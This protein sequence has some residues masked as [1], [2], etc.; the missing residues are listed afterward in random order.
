MPGCTASSA[1]LPSLLSVH[2]LLLDANAHRSS[3]PGVFWM[4]HLQPAIGCVVTERQYHDNNR[5]CR[6]GTGHALCNALCI[7]CSH[8]KIC[9]N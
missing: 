2:P 3:L 1:P 9:S 7:C 6:M 4:Q 5:E 8:F